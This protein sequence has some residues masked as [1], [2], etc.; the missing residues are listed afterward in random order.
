MRYLAVWY[1]RRF[2]VCES[3]TCVRVAAQADGNTTRE[4]THFLRR[5]RGPTR[6]LIVA[7]AYSRLR[8]VPSYAIW[9]R[10]HWIVYYYF[11]LTRNLH[12]P[13]CNARPY[14]RAVT[15]VWRAHDENGYTPARSPADVCSFEPLRR[16][17]RRGGGWRSVNNN[18]TTTKNYTIP[19]RIVALNKHVCALKAR[20]RKEVYGDG[21]WCCA[22]D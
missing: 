22:L 11:F 4:K 18:D 17:R 15:H 9:T 10:F 21:A 7:R 6:L 16:R 5:P 12:T 13:V 1:I 2:L 19:I 20:A 8:A 3:P 14:T